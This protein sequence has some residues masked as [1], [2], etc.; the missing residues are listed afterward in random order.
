MKASVT[1]FFSLSLSTFIMLIMTL[2]FLLIQNSEKV[3]FY[4]AFDISANSCL[5]EYSKALY[6][7]YDLLYVDTS[8]MNGES[9]LE[10]LKT[11]IRTY[12]SKNTVDVY[13]KPGGPWGDI[14]LSDV[15]VSNVQRA[16]EKGGTSMRN[17]A[18]K[19]VDRSSFIQGYLAE[20]SG[21][22]NLGK[23][24][25]IS[26]DPLEP[27]KSVMGTVDG[28]KRPKKIDE[29]THEEIEVELDNPAQAIF[30]KCGDGILKAAKVDVSGISEDSIDISGLCS[31]R[32]HED[33][34]VSEAVHGDKSKF[35]AYTLSKFGDYLHP[36][37][38]HCFSCELEYLVNGG[39]SDLNNLKGIAN[40]IFVQRFANNM[41]LALSDTELK[42]EAKAVALA[43]EICTMSPEFTEP[44]TL[45]I[46]M[47][48]AYQE[49]VS[50]V[51]SIMNGGRI[52][53]V[54][55]VHNMSVSRVLS[56]NYYYDE[57][58]EGWSYEQ[59]LLAMLYGLDEKLWNERVMDVM[60]LEIRKDTEN[61]CFSMDGC[62][63]RM[64]VMILGNGRMGNEL[65]LQRTYGFF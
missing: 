37:Y 65:V 54:K 18:L 15:E 49:T 50:D 40:S 47:A 46:L 55:T 32:N 48:A 61:P 16:T 10:K 58:N 14:S 8:Y 2:A 11:H 63:E 43:L 30:D 45:C 25:D 56:G 41:A 62:L 42:S 36:A 64:N 9:S 24:A 34:S 12:F 59:Y 28:L 21:V 17:Q 26:V 6:E 5:G 4:G 19:A 29:E 13:R 51:H 35:G 1:I 20:T 44:I 27:F 3:R 22:F 57:S 33:S 23:I 52:P 7:K 31:K 39:S 38:N 60:E 53:P